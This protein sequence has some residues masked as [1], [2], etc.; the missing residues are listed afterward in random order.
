M[1][2]DAVPT[3]AVAHETPKSKSG[4]DL[5]P[6]G[7][8]IGPVKR[9]WWLRRYTCTGTAVGLVFLWLSMTPSLLPRGPLFQGLVSGVSGA[10]GYA[11]GVL[12]V[13]LIR[14][15]RSRDSSGPAPPIAWIA[16]VGLGVAG[17]VLTVVWFHVWQD[18]VRD[19]LGVPHLK[20]HDYPLAAVL[21]IVT[22]FTFVEIGQ[23]IRRMVLFL[24]RQLNRAVP[25]RVSAVVAVLLVFALFVAIVNGVV[26]RFTM[27]TLNHTFEA[28]N[29]EESPN[30]PPPTTPLRSGGPGSLASWAS[31]GHQGRIFVDAATTTQQLS[32]FNGVSAVEPIR[33]YA[34]LGS[35]SGIQAAAELAAAELE[36]AGGLRRKVSYALTSPR[37]AELLATARAILTGV[38]AG[39]AETLEDRPAT[40]LVSGTT[41]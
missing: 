35:A 6:E 38:V 30:T 29:N 26:V 8:S 23:L 7:A 19:L 37:V 40:D 12:A 33:A 2:S 17:T 21:A 34:G 22:L 10:I 36:R 14:F 31:L 27:R 24:V 4:K 25:Q 3:S 32:A 9:P 5:T 13:W 20:W 18:R 15:M 41:S 16:L 11:L 1:S 39:Q 28:V